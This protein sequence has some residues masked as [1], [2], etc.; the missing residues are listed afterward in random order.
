MGYRLKAQKDLGKTDFECFGEVLKV[1]PSFVITIPICSVGFCICGYKLLT[2]IARASRNQT[3]YEYE[4]KAYDSNIVKPFDLRCR[5]KNTSAMLFKANTDYY[6]AQEIYRPYKPFTK[7]L[8]ERK[9]KIVEP[10]MVKVD[11]VAT[12]RLDEP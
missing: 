5:F 2:L 1:Y 7:Q 12:V 4:T 3:L 8:P 6:R 9:P 11:F 10:E